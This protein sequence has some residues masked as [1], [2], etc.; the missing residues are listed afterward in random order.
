MQNSVKA[1]VHFWIIGVVSLLWNSV[2][3]FD[4][5]AS[6]LKLDFYMSQFT[7]EQLAYFS[8]FPAWAIGAWAI[9]V[10]GALLGS[11]ALLLRKSWAVVLFGASLLGLAAS[12]VYNYVLTDG[13][14]A[15]GEGGAMFTAVIWV[16]ALFLFFY[17]RAMAKRG[18]LS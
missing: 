18:I 14:E 17:A 9:G 10:W 2:G 15:M 4:Y 16:I 7:P 5:S 8:G 6:Q 11:F 12:T 13:I 3:A 1:P